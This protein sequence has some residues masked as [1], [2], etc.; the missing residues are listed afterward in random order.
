M[1]CIV[2]V[3]PEEGNKYLKK[4]YYLEH[5]CLSNV[6]VCF[7]FYL[8]LSFNEQLLSFYINGTVHLVG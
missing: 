1:N 6:D 7:S 8:S 2:K 4:N 3:K 5:W